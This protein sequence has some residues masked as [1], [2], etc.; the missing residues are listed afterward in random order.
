MIQ[1]K[2]S[3]WGKVRLHKPANTFQYGQNT[4][5]YAMSVL[6]EQPTT[7]TGS[8]HFSVTCETVQW[9]KLSGVAF[10]LL[11]LCLSHRHTCASVPL[12]S[13]SALASCLTQH[14]AQPYY[15]SRSGVGVLCPL[16]TDQSHATPTQGNTQG[17]TKS[18]HPPPA[19]WCSLCP[20]S[21]G[22]CPRLS[23]V[24][25]VRGARWGRQ[26]EVR[27]SHPSRSNSRRRT[28]SDTCVWGVFLGG[29]C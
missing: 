19:M 16:P 3:V 14:W 25:R 29:G 15:S 9:S 13:K 20:L 24:R 11:C 22:H 6:C 4:F 7:R 17:N 28:N 10:S 5:Q 26:E 27:P 21:P 23:A 1:I 8:C 12:L 18:P 2:V